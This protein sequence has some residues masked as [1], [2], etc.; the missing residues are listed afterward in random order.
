M[1]SISPFILVHSY[2]TPNNQTILNSI[3]SCILFMCK[4]IH[5]LCVLTPEENQVLM[6]VWENLTNIDVYFTKHI[7]DIRKHI[8]LQYT[9]LHVN[10]KY[11]VTY[12]R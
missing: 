9:T 12:D 11:Q 2:H 10:V 4:C 1:G 3:Q 8:K 7:S 5:R 6:K